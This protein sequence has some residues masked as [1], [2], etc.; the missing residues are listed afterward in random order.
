MRRAALVCLLLAA[1]ARLAWAEEAARRF[2]VEQR[3]VVTYLNGQ[4][5]AAKS[6]TFTVRRDQGKG[7]RGT[8]F[9][10]CNTWFARVEIMDDRFAM[11]E[12][13]STEKFCHRDRM[14]TEMEFMAILKSLTRW[15]MDGR[16]LVLGGD[17]A[18]LLLVPASRTAQK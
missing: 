7:M 16:T 6:L 12:I 5:F 14:K 15:S 11:G 13:G 3:F 18:T 17:N 9:S 4:D 1:A 10:G 2:P 8:G